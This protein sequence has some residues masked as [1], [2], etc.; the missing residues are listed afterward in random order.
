MTTVIDP[1]GSP[2]AIFN[3]SGTAVLD[4]AINVG[5][6]EP[7]ISIPHF[8]GKTIARI[9]STSI[10]SP[11]N[12]GVELPAA[13]EIGDAV[14]VA[15]ITSGSPGTLRVYAPAGETIDGAASQ[16]VGGFVRF[17]KISGTDWRRG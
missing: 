12:G 15:Y 16:T 7:I 11:E 13:A 14:E 9:S 3:K 4:L 5:P 1:A 8:A 2:I 17:T 10:G 6:S